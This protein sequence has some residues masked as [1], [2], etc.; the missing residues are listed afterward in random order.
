MLARDSQVKGMLL[1]LIF[2]LYAR[3]LVDCGVVVRL[4]LRFWLLDRGRG[5][6]IG[7]NRISHGEVNS[8]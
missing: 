6:V 1:G 4:G 8:I 5:W 7:R 2:K 3:S